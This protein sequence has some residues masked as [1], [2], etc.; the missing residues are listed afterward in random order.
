MSGLPFLLRAGQ[1]CA[2]TGA[3]KLHSTMVPQTWVDGRAGA[4]VPCK[5]STK[6]SR[7]QKRLV[8][9]CAAKEIPIIADEVYQDNIWSAGKTFTSFRKVA[10][11]HFAQLK[12]VVRVSNTACGKVLCVREIHNAESSQKL[13]RQAYAGV[14]AAFDLQGLPGRVWPQG[15]LHERPPLPRRAAPAAREADEHLAVLQH[16]RPGALLTPQ[17]VIMHVSRAWTAPC[18][19]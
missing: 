14:L 3:H 18:M 12:P 8:E 1:P 17:H 6:S 4:T 15:W 7:L 5:L 2:S 9:L 11:D 16:A 13:H 19:R 10:L